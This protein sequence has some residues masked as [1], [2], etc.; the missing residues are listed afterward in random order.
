[1]KIAAFV[2]RDGDHQWGIID[3]EHNTILSAADLEEMYFTFLPETIN[4]LIEQGDDGL[5]ALESALQKH[6]EDP[7][8]QPY[9]LSEVTLEAPL[10]MQ[11][12]IFCI[13]KNYRDHVTEFEGNENAPIPEAP[14]FFSK[15][16]T[17]VIGP[18]EQ[19]NPHPEATSMADYEGE[20]AVIIGKR[21]TNIPESEALDYVFGYTILNDVTARDLQKKHVQWL[22]GKSLDTFCPMGPAILLSDKQPHIFDIKTHVN[23]ELKQ[24]DSTD[25]LI[26]SIEQL[27]A[28]ISQGIT[29]EPG[30]VISTGTPQGVGMGQR[31]PRFLQS[32]D[33]ISITISEIGTLTNS[34][35]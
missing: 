34:V 13:G 32:E 6:K 9:D 23:G 10:K 31:P 29:L 11:K 15:L 8:A 25:S 27:I 5:L 18:N 17:S 1:M 30:D 16:P 7:L 33:E 26:F 14:I 24:A 20:L 21:G 22:I 4:E 12:N 2:T 35:K 28:T 19:I 3:T